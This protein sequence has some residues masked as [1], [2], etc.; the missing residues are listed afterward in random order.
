MRHRTGK[1]VMENATLMKRKKCVNMVFGSTN[2]LYR[3]REKTDP[4]AKGRTMLPSA[5]DRE[6]LAL[7]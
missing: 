4:S 1:A 7:R 5:M 2:C 3:A 6:S